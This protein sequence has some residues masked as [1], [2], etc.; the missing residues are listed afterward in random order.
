MDNTL[1][2]VDEME[3]REWNR[4]EDALQELRDRELLDYFEYLRTR[5]ALGKGATK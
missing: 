3:A 4:A 2:E 1:D 5:V